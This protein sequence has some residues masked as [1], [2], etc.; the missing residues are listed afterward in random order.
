M[1]ICLLIGILVLEGVPSIH[2]LYRQVNPKS[3]NCYCRACAVA[4]LDE[5][6]FLTTMVLPLE[7]ILDTF[8]NEPVFLSID[9]IIVVKFGKHFEQV[10]ILLPTAPTSKRGHWAKRGKNLSL[11]NFTLDYEHDGFKLGNRRGLTIILAT[12]PSMPM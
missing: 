6:I 7:L 10:S 2:W 5:N 4:K 3:L 8:R 9:G 11:D 12:R 1:L